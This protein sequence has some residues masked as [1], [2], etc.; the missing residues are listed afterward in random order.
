MLKIGF[1]YNHKDDHTLHEAHLEDT[2]AEY[3][4]SDTIDA[5]HEALKNIS[6]KIV[7]LP[8]NLDFVEKVLKEKPDVVFNIAEGYGGRNREGY[9]P[10]IYDM[11]SIPY[12]GS[13]ALSLSLTLDKAHTKRIF[14][15]ENIPTPDFKLVS[16]VNDL[17]KINFDFPMFV[18][19]A[20][21]GTSK[22]IRNHSKVNDF[23]QLEKQVKWVIDNYKQPALVEKFVHGREFTS[24]VLENDSKNLLPIVEVIFKEGKSPF[25]SYECKLNVEET[26]ECPANISDELMKKINEYTLT[27][28]NL[29]DLRNL[30]RMDIRVGDDGIPQILEV[31]ALPGLS[32]KYSLYPVQARCA[33]YSYEEMI[34]EIITKTIKT[35]GL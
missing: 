33:G 24:G 30:A 5:I 25:Y 11:Y 9:A 3:E 15:S 23:A 27:V 10:T 2:A 20:R 12:T 26:L 34:C 22:G 1:S 19:P 31:N 4:E 17:I 13:D 21:E 14:R 6:H 28:Y 7:H 32:P 18:K 35:S 8:C 16:N 29:L